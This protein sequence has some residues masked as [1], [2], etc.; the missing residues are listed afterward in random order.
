MTLT[1]NSLAASLLTQFMSDA[2]GV[3]REQAAEVSAP[4]SLETAEPGPVD[5]PS[6]A[7]SEYAPSASSAPAPYAESEPAFGP[8]YAPSTASTE[9]P[10]DPI[11]AAVPKAAAPAPEAR[12]GSPHG[13]ARA[14]GQAQWAV[15][16]CPCI[17]VDRGQL[18]PR[19]P[20]GQRCSCPMCGHRS[21]H[22]GHGCH[23]RVPVRRDALGAVL[24]PYCERFCIYVLRWADGHLERASRR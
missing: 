23:F 18:G 16:N 22:R 9:A 13:R 5:A 4:E 2:E 3:H 7:G 19:E 1:V 10:W 21:I 14:R 17:N 12:P 6:A 8:E 11:G 15:C 24:C 20:D